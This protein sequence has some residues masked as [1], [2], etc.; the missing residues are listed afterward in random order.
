MPIFTGDLR[1]AA[2]GRC[3]RPG[4]PAA[5]AEPRR[6]AEP[7]R[8]QAQRRA[9]HR[10]GEDVGRVVHAE[11]GPGQRHRGRAAEERRAGAGRD[12]PQG[13]GGGEGRGR[14]GRGKE[15]ELGAP[16]SGGRPRSFGRGR[17]TASLTA[18]L[19]PIAVSGTAAARSQ[20]SRRSVSSG[21]GEGSRGPDRAPLARR[22]EQLDGAL[23]LGRV[24]PGTHQPE[25]LAIQLDEH[26]A[27]IMRPCP[28]PRK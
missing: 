14:V 16:A 25:Q 8:G 23:C 24:A 1:S 22:G 15:S 19:T 3:R 10:A 6:G 2:R 20:R 26:R 17:R 27:R 18:K 28:P 7:G 12:P 11:V 4:R 21:A 5:S 13:G 9:E